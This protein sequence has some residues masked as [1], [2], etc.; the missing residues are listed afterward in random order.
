MKKTLFLIVIVLQLCTLCYSQEKNQNFRV[1]FNFGFG[2]EIKNSDF[3]Y[4]NQYYKLQ[5]YYKLKKTN[6]FEYEILLQPEVNFA[7]HQLINEYFV[8][9]NEFN[10]QQK[11]DD[12]T[13]LKNIRE[14]ILNIG[15]VVRKPLTNTFSIYVLAS[16]G[17]L[18]ID[19]ET[20]RLAKGFAFSD[21]LALGLTLQTKAFSVDLRPSLRHLSNAGLQGSNAG[22]NTKN[23]ELGITFPL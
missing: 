7:T 4:T 12:Y 23:I 20:E 21:V 10:F 1:G 19:T 18:I 22:F 17:P 5:L 11:R 9:S 15:F 13:K 2:T 8:K 16:I 3:T 6:W 14:Y